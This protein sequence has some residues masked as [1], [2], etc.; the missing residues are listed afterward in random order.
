MGLGDKVGRWILQ[1][2]ATD[3]RWLRANGPR[4]LRMS[5]NVSL[6]QI[7]SPDFVGRVLAALGGPQG[8]A[9]GFELE[10]TENHVM[11][12]AASTIDNLRQI[13]G[14]GIGIAL[15]DFPS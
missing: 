3:M 9:S 13:R 2:A 14:L 12:D 7:G 4:S 1:Q 11:E 6:A 15:D 8:L 5:V 10:I